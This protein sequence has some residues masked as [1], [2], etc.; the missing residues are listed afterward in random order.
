MIRL[1]L[2]FLIS[3]LISCVFAPIVIKLTKKVGARQEILKYVEAHMGKQ[4]TPT[5]GGVIFVLP[6]IFV[7]L[8][9]FNGQANSMFVCLGVF[10]SYSLLGFLDDFIKVHTHKNLGLRAYQKVIGQVGIAVIIGFYMYYYSFTG[11][12]LNFPFDLSFDIGWVIIPFV[13][14]VFLAMTNSAN[15]TD[16]LDG[17]A[18]WTS[19]VMLLGFVTILGV[20][21]FD[22]EANGGGENIVAEYKNLMLIGLTTMGALLGFL[23]FNSYPAKIFMGDTGSL[24]LGGIITC[25]AVFSGWTLLLPI[26]CLVFVVSAVSVIIQVFH[27]KRTRKRVFLMA[28]LHHHFEKKGVNETKIVAIYIIITIVASAVAVGLTI[29]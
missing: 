16:G 27:F 22:L 28:P 10:F 5:M 11:G 2:A 4:G 15:L 24:A 12:E 1:I 25:L 14:F 20:T 26:V 8:L 19:F 6:A 23:A 21:M 7:A 29:M 13:I 9:F 3:F 17:L 18:G